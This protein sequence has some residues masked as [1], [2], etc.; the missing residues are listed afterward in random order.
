MIALIHYTVKFVKLI[1]S[2]DNLMVE[3]TY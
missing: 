3:N 1:V 2:P